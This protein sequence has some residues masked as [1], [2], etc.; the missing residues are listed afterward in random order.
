MKTTDCT[1]FQATTLILVRHGQASSGDAAF[2]GPD[3]PLSGLGRRQA[4]ALASNLASGPALDAIYSS[5]LPRALTT[6]TAVAERLGMEVVVD[7]RLAEFQVDMGLAA[8]A[9]ER[10]DL[11]VWHP[12]HMGV[13]GETMAQFA[14]RVAA[15]C[16]EVACRH[17]GERVAVICHA[18]TIEAALRWALDIAPQRPW[19]QEFELPNASITEVEFWPHGRVSGGVAPLLRTEAD[20]LCRATWALL[21]NGLLVLT[22]PPSPLRQQPPQQRVHERLVVARRVAAAA[23]RPQLDGD[24]RRA[25][26]LHPERPRLRPWHERVK[27]QRR[28]GLRLF[29]ATRSPPARLQRATI[30]SAP[31]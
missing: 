6:A 10:P 1:D 21:R 12:S 2:Y 8:S 28:M 29:E 16:E 30:S 31:A 13:D 20:R 26:R 22:A 17:P 27:V 18:G 24:P 25:P 19:Q 14:S 7:A 3:A 15:L 23:A 11:L 9:N 5:N 4:A